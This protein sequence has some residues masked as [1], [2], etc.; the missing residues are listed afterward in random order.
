M[1]RLVRDLPVIVVRSGRSPH[2]V[3]LAVALVVVALYG[4]LFSTPS[5]SI[6]SG[7]TVLQ[8]GLFAACT[9]IGAGLTLAGIYWRSLPRGLMIE[10]AGQVLLATG[11]ATY[12]VVLCT[13]STFDRS[14]LVTTVAC[15]IGIGSAWRIGQIG[16][17]LRLLRTAGR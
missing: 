6:D 2:S 10:R 16:R 15:G 11:A 13:V 17:D 12:V 4:L 3:S 9:V 7:L 1:D 5:V 14:G 8:R